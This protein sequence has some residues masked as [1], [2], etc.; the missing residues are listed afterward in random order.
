MVDIVGRNEQRWE[1]ECQTC[2]RILS[3]AI[4]EVVQKIYMDYGGG[5]DVGHRIVCPACDRWVMVDHVKG[6]LW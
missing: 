4:Y 2:H 5:C 1:V 3:F 6:K